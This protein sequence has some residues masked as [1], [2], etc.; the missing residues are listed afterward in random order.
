MEELKKHLLSHSSYTPPQA[1]LDTLLSA[2]DIISV[3]RHDLV[4]SAGTVNRN[5]YIIKDGLC[6]IAW[7]D[8]MKEVTYGFGGPGIITL[9]PQGWFDRK[10]AFYFVSAV[11]KSILLRISRD[12]LTGLMEADARLATWLFDQ[13]IHQFYALETKSIILSGDTRERV[14]TLFKKDIEK[15]LKPRMKGNNPYIRRISQRMLASYL[16]ITTSHLAHLRRELLDN[17]KS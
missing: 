14:M 13:A 15:A 5:L 16:G 7:F 12:R 2:C 11:E 10:E 17:S 9:S 4:I 1:S 8:G 3:D 6:R